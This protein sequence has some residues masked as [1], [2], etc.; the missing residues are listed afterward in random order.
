MFSF[1]VNEYWRQRGTLLNNYKATTADQEEVKSDDEAIIKL[2]Y[3]DIL[4]KVMEF[5]PYEPD[6]KSKAAELEVKLRE[7]IE[8]PALNSDFAKSL[9]LPSFIYSLFLQKKNDEVSKY[10]TELIKLSKSNVSCRLFYEIYTLLIGI[11]SKNVSGQWVELL[12]S[13]TAFGL[14]REELN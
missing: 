2:N 7:M 4:D 1:D 14:S 5:S 8:K 9:A 10:L 12:E 13:L 11:A 6:N 3:T